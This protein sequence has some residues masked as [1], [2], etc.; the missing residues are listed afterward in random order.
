MKTHAFDAGFSII[1]K[2]S[3][4]VSKLGAHWRIITMRTGTV[5]VIL[6]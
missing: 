2:I 3:N 5:A 4:S 6:A 1:V